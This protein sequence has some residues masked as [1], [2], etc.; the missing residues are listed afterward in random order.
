[1]IYL[2]GISNENKKFVDEVYET[3]NIFMDV[4]D[5]SKKDGKIG[6]F[7]KFERIFVIDNNEILF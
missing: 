7:E 1:M 3:I 5:V 2:S 6:K 4:Q